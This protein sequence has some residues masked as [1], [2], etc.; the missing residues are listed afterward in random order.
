MDILSPG[1]PTLEVKPL[2]TDT[3]AAVAFD[4]WLVTYSP[5]CF[6]ENVKPC[7]WSLLVH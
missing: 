4:V 5:L 3:V 2:F 1:S 6:A 7:F